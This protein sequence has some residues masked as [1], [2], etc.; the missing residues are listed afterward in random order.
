MVGEPVEEARVGGVGECGCGG[1]VVGAEQCGDQGRGGPA[2]GDGVVD[3]QDEGV[4]VGCG[5]DRGDAHQRRL[6]ERQ[7]DRPVCVDDRRD[8][9]RVVRIDIGMRKSDG[10]IGGDHCD[11]FAV[12]SGCDRGLEVGVCVR[13]SIKGDAEPVQ[14]EQPGHRHRSVGE[15]HVGTG[16][17][18]EHGFENHAVLEWCQWLDV[19]EVAVTL[20]PC[21]DIVVG[22]TGGGEV[23]Q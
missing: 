2:V 18:A 11:V 14:V 23:G 10:G 4:L 16:H 5:R 3:G 22:E 6:V 21:G 9:V 13:E 12:R 19:G 17:S 15:V 1:V 20:F 7:R 8:R